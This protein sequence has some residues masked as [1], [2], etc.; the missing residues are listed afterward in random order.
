VRTRKE[1][2]SHPNSLN[3]VINVARR[4]VYRLEVPRLQEFN[5]RTELR[6]TNGLF[7]A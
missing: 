4:V 2:W 1:G 7:R 5:R 6:R 3:Y